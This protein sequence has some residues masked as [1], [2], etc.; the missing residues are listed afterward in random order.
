LEI[1]LE[2]RI[3]LKEDLIV[4]DEVQNEPLALKSLKYFYEKMPEV[5]LVYAGS[6]LGVGLINESF[7]VGEVDYFDMYSLSFDKFLKEAVGD[8][9]YDQYENTK[10][11]G[12]ASAVLHEKFMENLKNYWITGGFPAAINAYMASR[13][14]QY[15]AFQ[16]AR[17]IQNNLIKDYLNDFSKHAGK[18]N[19]GHIR[20]VFE[21]IPTQLAA[22]I[23][24]SVNRY[25]FNDIIPGGKEFT[26][27][28]DPISWLKQAGLIYK[29][30][31][32]NHAAVPQKAFTKSNIFKIHI[33]D[34]GLLV[35]CGNSHRRL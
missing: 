12:E 24:D 29:V 6:L 26:A 8:F 20:M 9:L 15:E 31:I 32:C 17:H 19:S 18:L 28:E 4:V 2:K 25:V 21:N 13:Q 16:A 35:L 1:F 3:N 27:V 5:H 14:N 10:K 11:T 30:P 22:N 33:L 7:P 34:I 23:N